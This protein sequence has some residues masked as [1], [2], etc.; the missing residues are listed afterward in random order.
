MVGSWCANGETDQ[1]LFF[2]RAGSPSATGTEAGCAGSFPEVG[3]FAMEPRFEGD[4][5]WIE[6]AETHDYKSPSDIVKEE[7]REQEEQAKLKAM[8]HQ[9]R[10][11][12]VRQ[13][14]READIMLNNI[15]TFICQVNE[16]QNVRY[17]GQVDN[18]RDGMIH[19]H[20]LQ[21]YSL[22]MNTYYRGF[23]PVYIWADPH[24]WEL[25]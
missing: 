24:T 10:E 6:L 2:A 18:M 16:D 8:A 15:G 22:T 13:R 7:L 21:A 1:P 12:A 11:D 17:K 14:Q 9:V 25:C 20:I 4:P 19:V 5:K 23:D 3:I